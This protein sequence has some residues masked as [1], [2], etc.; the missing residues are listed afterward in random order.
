MEVTRYIV[1]QIMQPCFARHYLMMISLL[2]IA[3]LATYVYTPY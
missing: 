3:A 2:D 1:F